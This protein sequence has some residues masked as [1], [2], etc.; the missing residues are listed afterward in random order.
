MPSQICDQLKTA[1]AQLVQQRNDAE[2]A[3]DVAE[4]A[5]DVALAA[6]NA[7]FA[8]YSAAYS[9]RSAAIANLNS[10]VDQITMNEQM[11]QMNQCGP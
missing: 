11:Q 8:T 5:Y 7:A 3:A 1:H 10:I 6:F 4:A 9:A 2:A